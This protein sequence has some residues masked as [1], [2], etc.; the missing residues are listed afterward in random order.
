MAPESLPPSGRATPTRRDLVAALS[1]RLPT[2]SVLD[3]LKVRYR[4]YI[5]PF[6]DLLALL[7]AGAA[8]FDVGC[9]NGAFLYLVAAFRRPR[10]LGGVE[11]AER[12]VS[13]A[14]TLLVREAA[15]VPV[16]LRVYDGETVPDDLRDYQY[17]FLI[18]VLHHVP[19]SRQEALLAQIG[20]RMAPG[21]TLVLK[22]IDAADRVL[23]SF[24]KL[25]DL[26]LTGK[27]GHEI[28]AADAARM[29]TR[30]GF[31]VA[32]PSK[33]RLLWYSHYTVVAVKP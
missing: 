29:L 18:D 9:G 17:V 24:N 13:N 20:A 26:L 2:A 32:A 30:S 11:I 27:A 12:L 4:P 33:R 21:A 19:A 23:R 6:D 10:A 22:D 15:T 1:A 7:P 25:H 8:V 5:C 3:R 16:S 31:R 14:R 28:A